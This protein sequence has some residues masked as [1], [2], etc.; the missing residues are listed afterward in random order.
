MEAS[1]E[2]I[3]GNCNKLMEAIEA[4]TSTD[5]GDLHVFPWKH[6]RTSMEINIIPPTSM[7]VNLLPP[8]SMEVS[9]NFRME[10]DRK[11]EIMWR[12]LAAPCQH[13]ESTMKA[14]QKYQ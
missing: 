14:P 12:G 2:H 5:S 11:N 6:P 7:K 13:H 4:S 3:R 9:G 8:T 10:V 1:T